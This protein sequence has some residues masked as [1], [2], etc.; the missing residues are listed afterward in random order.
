L[1]PGGHQW[2]PVGTGPLGQRMDPRQRSGNKK[3]KQGQKRIEFKN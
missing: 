3:G 1:I 2:P